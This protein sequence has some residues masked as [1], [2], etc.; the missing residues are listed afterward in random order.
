MERK[1]RANCL[2]D[3]V[4]EFMNEFNLKDVD[5]VNGAGIKKNT[6]HGWITGQVYN[7]STD[8]NLFKLWIY[9]NKFKK[10]SLEYLLYGVGDDGDKKEAA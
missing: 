10:V 9:V 7:P 5:V 4:I 2:Q 6:W 1:T 3:M 8:E